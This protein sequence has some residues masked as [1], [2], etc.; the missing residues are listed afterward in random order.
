MKRWVKKENDN[1]IFIQ[2][3][4]KKFEIQENIGVIKFFYI[5]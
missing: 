1:F 3:G 5:F 4:E 2:H